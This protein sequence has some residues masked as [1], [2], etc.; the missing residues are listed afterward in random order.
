MPTL[1]QEPGVD[2]E[3]IELK[4]RVGILE[5]KLTQVI[6]SRIMPTPFSFAGALDPAVGI[7][8]PAWR[9][10]HPISV[11]L[12]VPQVL[13]APSGGDLTID[14]AQLGPLAGPVLT[15]TIPDGQTYVEVAA[16][17]NVPMG[18]SVTAEITAAFGADT[19]SISMVPQLL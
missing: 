8:S 13:I 14:I 4:R 7:V 10:V 9:P 3:I 17:F 16:P 1:S 6:E 2:R 19:L 12:L 18:G 11:A 15:L 5:R